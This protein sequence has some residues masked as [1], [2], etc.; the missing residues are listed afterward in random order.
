MTFPGKLTIVAAMGQLLVYSLLLLSRSI[1]PTTALAP[2]EL[3]FSSELLRWKESDALSRVDTEIR[4]Q[5][6]PG[7]RKLSELVNQAQQTET[8]TPTQALSNFHIFVRAGM[9]EESLQEIRDLKRLQRNASIRRR[10][11]SQIFRYPSLRSC[12]MPDV[13]QRG[14]R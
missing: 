13:L 11:K 2:A 7:Q 10:R 9:Y 3:D 4:T 12:R 1:P 5:L 6:L 14:L 8:R